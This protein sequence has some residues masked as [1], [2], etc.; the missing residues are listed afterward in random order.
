MLNSQPAS[1]HDIALMLLLG[2]QKQCF[3]VLVCCGLGD[4]QAE[5]RE[6]VLFFN[7]FF[8]FVLVNY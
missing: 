1:Q 2:S 3:L 6:G 5:G 7:F 8:I 4:E